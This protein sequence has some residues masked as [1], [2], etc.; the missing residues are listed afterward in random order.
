MELFVSSVGKLQVRLAHG[1][2]L[3]H[4]RACGNSR[5]GK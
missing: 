2:R 1:V 4:S 3:K 5:D